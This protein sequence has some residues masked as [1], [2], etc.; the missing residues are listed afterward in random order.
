MRKKQVKRETTLPKIRGH[1]K[2]MGRLKE[3]ELPARGRAKDVVDASQVINLSGFQ[4]GRDVENRESGLTANLSNLFVPVVDK[5]NKPL[6]PTTCSRAKRWIKDGKATGFWKRGIYCVRLNVEPSSRKMQQI[7][8]GIDTGSKK[9]AFTIKSRA[10]TY[11]NIQTDAVTWVKENVEIRKVA[12]GGRRRR[13]TPYRK[14]RWNRRVNQN[15]IAPSTKARWQWKLRI[16]NWLIK[17]YPISGFIVENLKVRM[18]KEKKRWNRVFSPLQIG[19]SWF[20]AELKK[21][22]SLETKS[23]W[24]TKLL[25]DELGLKKSTKKMSG[26]FEAHCLDSWVLV[27]SVVGGHIQPENKSMLYIKPLRFHRRQLHV[28]NPIKGGIRKNYGGTISMGFKR[29]S[30]V[31]HKNRGLAFV[32]GSSDFHKSG[33]KI[34]LYDVTNG[35]R[36]CQNAKSNEIKFLSYNSF[37]VSK[38]VA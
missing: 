17:M 2:S 13:T 38:K 22:G 8:V 23:G 34:S 12:R 29:G 1:K 7:V 15:F 5:L 6:M 30:L 3:T 26:V 20:Y 33:L 25:R 21:I 24:E 28:Q 31:V 27:N 11:L 14:V 19:K 9:E 16:V 37:I 4:C 32:G 36:L 10:H 18:K 35:L